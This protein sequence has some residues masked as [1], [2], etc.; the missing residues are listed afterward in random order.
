PA[1]VCDREGPSGRVIEVPL[2]FTRST[3]S[4]GR[5]R[6]WP[7]AVFFLTPFF[8]NRFQCGG[9]GVKAAHAPSAARPGLD[10]GALRHYIATPPKKGVKKAEGQAQAE[11]GGRSLRSP[12]RLGRA[13]TKTP[14]GGEATL[15]TGALAIGKAPWGM[16]G[17]SYKTTFCV[18]S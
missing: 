4:L 6:G 5:F 16:G 10:A 17:L 1:G 13:A 12:G 14:A 3:G 9:A 15:P 2:G 18:R 11:R 8:R 7:S